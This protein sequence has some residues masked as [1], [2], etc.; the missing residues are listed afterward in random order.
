MKK[1]IVTL[2]AVLMLSITAFAGPMIGMQV[3][4]APD[5][6]AALIVG[7]DF[8][9]AMVEGGK[10]NYGSWSGDWTI[11]GLWTPEGS[12]E[13]KYRLGPK[14]TWTW[15]TGGALIYS[16]FDLVVG[17]SKTW[18][19]FQIMGELDIGSG[20]VLRVK[21]LLGLNI[22]FSGFFPTQTGSVSE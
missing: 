9:Y 7:W 13:F 11:A 10:S 15:G 19:A 4:P 22:L 8:G 2:L 1:L 12:Y 5:T 14:M 3:V 16:G 18:G 17:V 20:G 21:P 6:A